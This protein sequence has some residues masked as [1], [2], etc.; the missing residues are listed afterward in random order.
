[1]KRT[2]AHRMPTVDVRSDN[3]KYPIKFWPKH[4]WQQRRVIESRL[5][6]QINGYKGAE[7]LTSIKVTSSYPEGSYHIYCL[8]SY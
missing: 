6:G 3:G 1:M 8:Y 7:I 5:F 4:E 2:F